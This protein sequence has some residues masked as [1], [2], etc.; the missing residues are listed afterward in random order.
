MPPQ[1]PDKPELLA[2]LSGRGPLPPRVALVVLIM[3]AANSA[4]E[5]LVVLSP[6]GDR[7][8]SWNKVGQLSEPVMDS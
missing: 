5:A 3:P 2:H 6:Q 1:E 8:T 4:A 7:I